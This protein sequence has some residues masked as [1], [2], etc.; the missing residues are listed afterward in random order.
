MLPNRPSCF[1]LLLLLTPFLA[2][3]QVRETSRLVVPD[4]FFIRTEC[5]EAAEDA[6]KYLP[7][8]S[9]DVADLCSEVKN[10]AISRDE[11]LARIDPVAR[12]I[13]EA[14]EDPM[15]RKMF[16]RKRGSLPTGLNAYVLFLIPSPK[17]AEDYSSIRLL[18]EQFE[19]LGE[20]IGT[21]Q[22]AVW[23][24]ERY[25]NYIDVARSKFYCDLFRLNYNDGP[26]VV[27]TNVRP[28]DFSLGEEAVVVKLNDIAPKRILMILNVLEQD[29]RTEQRARQ[30]AL[31]FEEIKQRLLSIAERHG[32][33]IKE[34]A[35]SWLKK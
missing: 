12:D 1:L 10:G 2:Q 14:F 21:K 6:A 19:E 5:A 30:R 22:A 34:I 13:D 27:V 29:L 32:D 3:G 35:V 31:I 16:L 7:T 26:Y 23:L 25:S 28:D 17:L 4:D 11:W 9:K 8:R 20:S 18:K 15:G 24:G 33:D